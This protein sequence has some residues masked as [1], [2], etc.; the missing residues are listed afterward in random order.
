MLAPEAGRAFCLWRHS[1]LPPSLLTSPYYTV[2]T[3]QLATKGWKLTPN[4]GARLDY[5]PRVAGRVENG[6]ASALREGS[7]HSS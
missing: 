7:P 1:V 5:E 6:E 4:V 2:A 3:S